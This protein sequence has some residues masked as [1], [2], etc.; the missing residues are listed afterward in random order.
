[1]LDEEIGDLGRV[2]V[3]LRL[4]RTVGVG[5]GVDFRFFYLGFIVFRYLVV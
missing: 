5:L 4:Y 3:C 1:M 2:D